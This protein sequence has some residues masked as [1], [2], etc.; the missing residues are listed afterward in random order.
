[1]PV[2]REALGLLLKVL[3]EHTPGV[4]EDLNRIGHLAR[5]TA[6]AM[7]MPEAE[8]ERVEIA[9]RLHDVGKLAI[10]DSIL[11]KPGPLDGREW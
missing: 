1:M 7:G 2:E 3:S 9:G 6:L 8:A 4:L 10:P 5:A 11:T